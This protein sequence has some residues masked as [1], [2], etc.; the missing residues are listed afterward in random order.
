LNVKLKLN[1]QIPI[2]ESKKYDSRKL[3]DDIDNHGNRGNKRHSW[4]SISLSYLYLVG[5]SY[6][7]LLYLLVI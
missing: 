7:M 3:I 1:V 5:G 4:Y 6:N 2:R